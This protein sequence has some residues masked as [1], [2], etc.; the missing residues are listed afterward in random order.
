MIT[1]SPYTSPHSG[2]G[3]QYFA[4]DESFC[5]VTNATPAAATARF[6][7]LC[8]EHDIELVYATRDAAERRQWN[9]AHPGQGRDWPAFRR[10]EHLV[11][12]LLREAG[13]KDS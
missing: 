4:D 7:A 2:G 12:K 5:I 9:H 11:S 10:L 8:E 3:T 6:T 13:I 1:T